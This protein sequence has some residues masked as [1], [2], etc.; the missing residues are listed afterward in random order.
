MPPRFRDKIRESAI[1]R[2]DFLPGFPTPPVEG[3]A[4]RVSGY[5]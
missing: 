2:A 3:F 5:R 1:F 4:M